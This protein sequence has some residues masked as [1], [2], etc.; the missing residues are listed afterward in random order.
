MST[1]CHYHFIAFFFT[2]SFVETFGYAVMN[3][4][5]VGDREDNK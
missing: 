5:E 4:M 2:N 3:G 1:E